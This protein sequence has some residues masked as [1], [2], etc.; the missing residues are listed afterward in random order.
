MRRYQKISNGGAK[1]RVLPGDKPGVFKNK[2][3]PR[4]IRLL[5]DRPAFNHFGLRQKRD[6]RV[7]FRE[8]FFFIPKAGD[9]GFRKELYM[10]L[11]YCSFSPLSFWNKKKAH[12]VT[13]DP[14][15]FPLSRGNR[16]SGLAAVPKA[17]DTSRE[18]DLRMRFM[19]GISAGSLQPTAHHGPHYA[20]TT[21]GPFHQPA[22]STLP[23]AVD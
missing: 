11:I 23:P 16:I 7:L 15:L 21:Q 10:F 20:L 9:L 13:H 2:R 17:V 14:F 1:C 22:I 3:N 8:L 12:Y 4:P 6:E 5:I 19:N 18:F